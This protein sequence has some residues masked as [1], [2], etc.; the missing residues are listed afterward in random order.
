MYIATQLR[1][2]LTIMMSINR[3]EIPNGLQ[4]L[5]VLL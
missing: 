2:S 5:W 4:Q 1:A 3:G